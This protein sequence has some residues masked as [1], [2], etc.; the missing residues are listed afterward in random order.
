[1][2]LDF[3]GKRKLVTKLLRKLP[4]GV[5]FTNILQA[6]F[7]HKDPKSKKMTIKLCSFIALLGSVRIKA[8]RKMLVKLTQRRQNKLNQ[9]HHQTILISVWETRA[10]RKR[11]TVKHQY[12]AKNL[13]KL[14]KGEWLN[15]SLW[16][17]TVFTNGWFKF[18]IWLK[19][20]RSNR[21]KKLLNCPFS[22]TSKREHI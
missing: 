8:A 15:D 1:M 9:V 7:M 18:E 21:W 20:E 11:S 2:C 3:F 16:Q 6:A 10:C 17:I 22:V 19:W 4:Q 5:N 13:E 12:H 14:D